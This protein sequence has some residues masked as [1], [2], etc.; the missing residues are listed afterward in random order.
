MELLI[1]C[2]SA[3]LE[4]PHTASTKKG[5]NSEITIHNLNTAST[6]KGDNPEITIHN[7][8]YAC[9]EGKC[10]LPFSYLL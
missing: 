6:K 1:T 4:V 2:I 3:D 7:L 9:W 8:K 10:Y 5:D